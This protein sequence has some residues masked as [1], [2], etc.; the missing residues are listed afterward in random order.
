MRERRG[1]LRPPGQPDISPCRLAHSPL[2][3]RSADL[4]WRP[5]GRPAWEGTLGAK[6][7]QTHFEGEDEE[8]A[9]FVSQAIF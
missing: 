6:V 5:R 4:G 3:A 7:G 2:W 9:W 1:L 8:Q